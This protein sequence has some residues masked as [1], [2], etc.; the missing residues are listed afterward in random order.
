MDTVGEGVG[1]TNGESSIET[2]TLPYIKRIASGNLLSDTGSSN[3]VLCDNLDGWDGVGAGK[4]V[5]EEGTKKQR[6]GTY[7]YLW[8]IP[9]DMSFLQ[10]CHSDLKIKSSTDRHKLRVQHHQ[11]SFT[12]NVKGTS[13]SKK[14]KTQ[15]EI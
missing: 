14:E 5:Q 15:L 13:P 10:I 6:K 9:V 4:E 1:E 3:L 2:H 11:T 12:G 8:L 7:I